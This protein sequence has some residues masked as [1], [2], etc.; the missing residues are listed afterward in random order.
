MD[1]DM[2]IDLDLEPQE[3]DFQEPPSEK[4]FHLISPPIP[5]NELDGQWNPVA[6]GNKGMAEPVPSSGT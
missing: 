5:D 4:G 3:V 6:Y 2:V 1:G